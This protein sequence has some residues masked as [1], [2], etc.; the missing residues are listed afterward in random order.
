MET[1]VKVLV[2][3]EIEDVLNGRPT[4]LASGVAFG[5]IVQLEFRPIDSTKFSAVVHIELKPENKGDAPV[6]EEYTFISTHRKTARQWGNL[7][8][9]LNAM[10][11]ILPGFTNFSITPYQEN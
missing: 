6:V 8:Q 11:K 10:L 3:K 5:T 1:S 7:S 9:A 2:Q 4:P